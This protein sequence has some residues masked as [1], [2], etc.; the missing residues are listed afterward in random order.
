MLTADETAPAGTRWHL[1]L[2]IMRLPKPRLP[3]SN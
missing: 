1:K 3:D 2:A